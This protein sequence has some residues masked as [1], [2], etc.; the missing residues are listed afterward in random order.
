MDNILVSELRRIRTSAKEVRPY[1]SFEEYYDKVFDWPIPDFWLDPVRAMEKQ[2]RFLILVP[3][4]HRKTTTLVA[5]AAW[6]IGTKKRTRCVIVSHTADFAET[7]LNQV[8]EVLASPASEALIGKVIP[9]NP[10][11]NCPLWRA[12]ARKIY[13]NHMQKEP[14]LIAIGIEGNALGFRVDLILCDDV[15]TPKNSYTSAMRMKISSA[16]WAELSKRLEPDGQI[17]VSGS[18][19]YKNDV[20][21]EILNNPNWIHMKMMTTPENPL[22]PGRFSKEWLANERSTNELFFRSQYLQEP[23]ADEFTLALEDLHHYFKLPDSVEYYIGVDPCEKGTDSSDFFS[24]AVLA[25]DSERIAYVVDIINERLEPKYQIEEVQ[26]LCELYKPSLVTV[27]DKGILGKL[28]K[29]ELEYYVRLSPSNLPKSIRIQHLA[30]RF[31]SSKIVL[32]ANI[33]ESGYEP[34]YISAQFAKQWVG[35]GSSMH[36]DM[37]DAMEK[38]Y[39]GAITGG[40]PALSYNGI[41]LSSDID[42]EDGEYEEATQYDPFN[43]PR[44]RF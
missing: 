25:V 28:L 17:I 38:A 14:N 9:D 3:P 33:K 43:V 18:R 11:H 20:Y 29:D 21:E 30:E 16:F 44:I 24:A 7:I 12:S 15:I 23:I 36:D 32:P 27:E 4:G 22:W 39:E 2:Q 42:D 31:K 10:E 1:V 35:F 41:T 37:L 6:A 34:S 13:V 19:F 5:Y 8:T 26:K 40:E